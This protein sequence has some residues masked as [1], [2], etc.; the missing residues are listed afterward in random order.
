MAITR[1]SVKRLNIEHEIGVPFEYPT[2]SSFHSNNNS[3]I[4]HSK[5]DFLFVEL[6]LTIVYKA[7]EILNDRYI[8]IR[9][10][11][12]DAKERL[13]PLARTL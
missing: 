13:P 5:F 10:A 9:D 8:N 7:H 1:Q 12:Y 2:D 6:C 11:C 3:Y 4:S